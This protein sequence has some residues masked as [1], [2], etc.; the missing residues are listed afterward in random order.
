MSPVTEDVMKGKNIVYVVGVTP[1]F[2][3]VQNTAL[4][5]VNVTEFHRWQNE[6]VNKEKILFTLLVS[7]QKSIQFEIRRYL[8]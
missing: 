1:N 2:D 8:T 5:H 7:R 6:D 4:S 3:T